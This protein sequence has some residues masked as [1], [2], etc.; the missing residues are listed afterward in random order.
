M[1]MHGL[2]IKKT[3]MW[4]QPGLEAAPSL[5]KQLLHTIG[6]VAILTDWLA[7]WLAG[8]SKPFP[9]PKAVVEL[10]AMAGFDHAAACYMLYAS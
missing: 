9:L 1:C 10:F 2:Q 6:T 5:E 7:S 8:W 3:Q 4:K